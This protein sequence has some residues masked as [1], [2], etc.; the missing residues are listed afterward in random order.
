MGGSSLPHHAS[1][2]GHHDEGGESSS[3]EISGKGAS[4]KMSNFVKSNKTNHAEEKNYLLT[5]L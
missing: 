5:V 2:A 3:Q 4:R 1:S